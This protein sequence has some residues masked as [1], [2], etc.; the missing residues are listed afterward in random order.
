MVETN[1]TEVAKASQPSFSVALTETLE[2]N[3]LALPKDF[4][5][6][7]FVQN[8]V[9]LMN[10]NK[11][12]QD[13]AKQYGTAQ[14]KQGMM[15]AAYLGLDFINKEAHLVKF[16][17]DLNFMID[18]RGAEKLVKKYSPRPVKNIYAKLV[19]QG[20]D[21]EE[22]IVN[23]EQTINFKPLPFNGNPI[24]GA[25]AV[26]EFTDGGMQYET[27][28]L[29][30][31]ENTRSSSKAKNSPAWTKFTGEMYKKTVLHRLCKHITIDFENVE[32][33]K[34]FF[35][36]SEIETDP[37]EQAKADMEQTATEDFTFDAEFSEVTE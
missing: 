17:S 26:C 1:T 13:Y 32:Q 28:S 14:I 15:R 22:A 35:E 31:L 11:E 9:A 18:Y 6:P 24:I 21:F 30:E 37:K 4:N 33:N 27:M 25:F 3:K 20:D 2:E 5:I 19:R 23:G 8:G 12:L 29:D 16:G 10:S 36:D 34:I 7:R